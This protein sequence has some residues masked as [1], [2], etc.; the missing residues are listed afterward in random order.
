MSESPSFP[1]VVYRLFHQFT[2]PVISQLSDFLSC[3]RKNPS[4]I[5]RLPWTI[6]RRSTAYYASSPT[7]TTIFEIHLLYMFM[8]ATTE[9]SRLTTGCWIDITTLPFIHL[10]FW[11][12]LLWPAS[13][14]TAKSLRR[15]HRSQSIMALLKPPYT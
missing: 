12:S 2:S 15:R 6:P 11:T 5:V 10:E 3:L 14:S 1:S 8:A 9:H 4:L 13:P 7:Y